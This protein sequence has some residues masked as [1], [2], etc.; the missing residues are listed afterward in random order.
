MSLP[1]GKNGEPLVRLSLFGE[2]DN[3]DLKEIGMSGKIP[4]IDK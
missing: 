2:H 1:K 4:L 3:G